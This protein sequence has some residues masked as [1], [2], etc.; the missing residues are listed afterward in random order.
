MSN[1]KRLRVTS[2][3][4]QPLFL[5]LRTLSVC[6]VL[7]INVCAF[8]EQKFAME[9]Q[10][11]A[12]CSGRKMTSGLVFIETS[13]ATTGDY[14]LDIMDVAL[15]DDAKYQCQVSSG[16]RGESAIRSRYAR[17]TVLVPPEP[18]KILQ[19]NFYST[20]EDRMIILECVSI[21]GKP[22]AE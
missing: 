22:P 14:S 3:C 2:K 12:N 5:L 15:E 18:P 11:Q 19:G 6:V 8:N 16:M 20:T 13:E 10:D 4:F 21:G 1:Y 7:S 17:L 9:P